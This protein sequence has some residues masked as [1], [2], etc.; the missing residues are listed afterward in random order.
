MANATY[1]GTGT[2][3][4]SNY[5]IR[6]FYISN[7][8]AGTSSKRSGIG[9][10]ALTIA[11][12]AALRRA[13]KNLGSSDYS[14][15]QDTSIRNSVLAYIQTYNNTLS[16]AS[17]SGDHSLERNAKQLKSIAKEYSDA[18][19]KIGITINDDGTLTSREFL[20]KSADLSKFKSLFSKDS[21]F[22]QRTSACAKRI[23]SRSGS[24]KL[25][26]E[27]Q[28]LKTATAKKAAAADTAPD[29]STTAAQLLA[30]SLALDSLADTSVGQNINIVL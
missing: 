23:E 30:E 9:N 15:S 2:T 26:E 1:I 4:S 12:S 21:E 8:D 14:E 18:L 5:Y 17:R 28:K 24:L 25:A 27:N 20:F 6:N 3:L 16:S 11:D 29:T 22:M 10:S 19:D 7:R 13:I